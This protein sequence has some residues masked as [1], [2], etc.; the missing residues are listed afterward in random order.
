MAFLHTFKLQ[1]SK[2]NYS[3]PFKFSNKQ[4]V[5]IYGQTLQI[6]AVLLSHRDPI[7]FFKLLYRPFRIFT[8]SHAKKLRDKSKP[9][10]TT[11]KSRATYLYSVSFSVFAVRQLHT[12]FLRAGADVMQTFTFYA[13]EDKLVNRGHTAGNIGVIYYK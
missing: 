8:A 3:R 10:V 11:V 12:E 5:Y 2:A 7:K 13:S 1:K 6:Y 4:N 9:R